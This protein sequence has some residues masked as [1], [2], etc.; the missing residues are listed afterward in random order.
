MG[1][2]QKNTLKV[3]SSSAQITLIA[4]DTSFFTREKSMK[5]KLSEAW[6]IIRTVIVMLQVNPLRFKSIWNK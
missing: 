2:L 4:V 3:D 1:R 5:H 6:K